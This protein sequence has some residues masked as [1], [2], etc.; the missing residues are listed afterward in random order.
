MIAHSDI[1]YVIDGTGHTRF[2]LDSDPGPASGA[3]QSSFS[4]LLANAV[5]RALAPR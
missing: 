5:T 1:T 4:D 2:V 3:T